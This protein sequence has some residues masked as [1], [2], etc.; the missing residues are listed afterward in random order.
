MYKWFFLFIYITVFSLNLSAIWSPINYLCLQFEHHDFSSCHMSLCLL[1]Q[2][3]AFPPWQVCLLLFP[4][5]LWENMP[6]I[7]ELPNSGFVYID[8]HRTMF[9]LLGCHVILLVT[10]EPCPEL[11]ADTTT[12]VWACFC[13]QPWPSLGDVIFWQLFSFAV[14][15]TTNRWNC[16]TRCRS[17][18]TCWAPVWW[19]PG[20]LGL[21]A[22]CFIS[23]MRSVVLSPLH[24]SVSCTLKWTLRFMI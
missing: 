21:C 8:A 16:T 17:S 11:S 9:C 6:G 10:R 13:W 15:S 7:L 5:L 18:P 1:F 3:I 14:R 12:S 23:V 19:H 22:W 4:N 20:P 2:F 24:A